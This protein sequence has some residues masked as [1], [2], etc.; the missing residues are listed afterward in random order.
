MILDYFKFFSSRL[1][2]SKPWQFKIPLLIGFTYFFL[3]TS[4]LDSETAFYSFLAAICT[5]IGFAGFGYLTN[6]LSDIKKDI[7]VGKDNAL[8]SLSKIKLISIFLFFISM[9]ILPWSYLPFDKISLLLIG[10][11]FALFVLY[12]FPPFRLKEKGVFGVITDSLYAHVNPALLASWTFFKL[13]GEKYENFLLFIIFLAGWQFI[14]GIRNILYHQIKD[15]END[16]ASDIRTFVTTIGKIR[17]EKWLIRF[18]IP[19]ELIAFICFCYYLQKELVYFLPILGLFWIGQIVWFKKTT[20]VSSNPKYQQFTNSFLDEF[21]IQWVPV[22]ILLGM[23]MSPMWVTPILL[24]HLLLFRSFPKTLFLRS[25]K[26]FGKLPIKRKLFDFKN[27]Y[28]GLILHLSILVG[29]FIVFIITYFILQSQIEDFELFYLI[30]RTLS[31]G[32]IGLILIHLALLIYYRWSQCI[33]AGKAFV[34]ESGSAYNLAIFRILFFVV[35]MG[36]AY[37]K[38]FGD[39]AQWAELPHSS[40]VG[41]PFI[42]WLVDIIPITPEIYYGAGVALMMCSVFILV[43]LFTKWAFIIYVPLALYLWGVPCFFGKISHHHMAVWIPMILAFS[44]S[45]K[46]LSID[47]LINKYIRKRDLGSLHHFSFGLPFKLLWILIA[48]VY[49]C[50]GLHKLWDTGLYWALSDNLIHQ[51]QL[52][53]VE[54]YDV[55][56]SIRIDHFPVLA[57]IGGVLIIMFEVIYPL[58]IIKPLTRTLAFAGSWTLHLTASFFLYIDFALLRHAHFSYVNW[59]RWAKKI[60]KPKNEIK[61]TKTEHQLKS[62][63]K[64]PISYVAIVF[65]TFNLS[66]GIFSISSWPFSTFPSYSAVVTE[67]VELIRMDAYDKEQALIPVKELA[68]E[69]GLAWENIRPFEQEIASLS[70]NENMTSSA[71]LQSKLE[72]YWLLWRSK[73]VGLENVEHVEMYLEKTALVPEERHIVLTSKY[74]G[75]IEI[76]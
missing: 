17:T 58:L 65:I 43:G 31:I 3:L 26:L 6:D 35:L 36:T 72:N 21:Y 53:W 71:L 30:Q 46:V 24:C 19:L 70:N 11:Q 54:N 25:A 57:K 55:I 29:Y 28:K 44:Q 20:S 67:N 8:A 66:F 60:L 39:F 40:R 51:V 64:Y 56:S 49:C 73:V 10:I 69:Q 7:A 74:L 63:L 13:G 52:E 48:I 15:F 62:L 23:V 22:M 41:L 32:L 18:I 4:E 33:E 12:A 37:H 68:K 2:L 9:A 38:V 34:F 27:Y 14:S 61:Q 47:F 50:S 1:R 59:E 75:K 76:E 42:E 16:Q 5:T 45:A